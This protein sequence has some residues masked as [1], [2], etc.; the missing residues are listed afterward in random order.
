MKLEAV[1]IKGKEYVT[2]NERIKAFRQ[3]FA[4]W[5]LETEIVELTDERCVMKAVIKDDKGDIKA[6]GTA[7]ELANSTY[8][9]KT[10]YVEN[11]ETSAWGRALG[12]LG[13]GVDTSIVSAEEV[14]NAVNNQGVP[15][16]EVDKKINQK[17]VKTVNG[18][19]SIYPQE[20]RQTTLRL[21]LAKYGVTNLEDLNEGQYG[22][23]LPE[24]VDSANS[25][26]PAHLDNLIANFATTA[27]VDTETA[28]QMIEQGAKVSLADITVST[29][30]PFYKVYKQMY[31]DLG[32]E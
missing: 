15:F 5:S 32:N 21:A 28:Q 8:I 7:Y 16:L 18:I 9:N 26:L 1:N 31:K 17:Q 24:L 22:K 14:Q 2:V 19:L 12:N 11:C 10:S 27:N 25:I 30:P 13:I 20:T 6:T 23:F 4:G 29:Y 3:N